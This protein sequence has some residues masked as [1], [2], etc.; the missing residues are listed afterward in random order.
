MLILLNVNAKGYKVTLSSRKK[1]KLAF[2]SPASAS[3]SSVANS[4]QPAAQGGQGSAPIPAA[5]STG[6]AAVPGELGVWHG[7][8]VP[9]ASA[10]PLRWEW[11]GLPGS[12]LVRG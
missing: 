6:A 8:D 12:L 7:D 1:N 9:A 4:E 10:P 3:T 11:G 2:G 5:S